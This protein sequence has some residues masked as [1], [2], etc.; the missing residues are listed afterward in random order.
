M[1]HDVFISHS[2]NDK[3][4]ADAM[5]HK[6]ESNGIRCWIAPR[7]ILPGVEWGDAIIQALNNGR[8]M[9]LV[10]S[11]KANDSQQIVKEVDRAA[12]KRVPIVAFRIE[13]VLPLGSLEYYLSNVHWLDAMTPPM[14]QHLNQLVESVKRLLQL[15]P[16][17]T[18]SVPQTTAA[19]PPETATAT[20][21]PATP[22]SKIDEI[23][24]TLET[25]VG[26]ELVYV[27]PGSFMMGSEY[28][29]LRE[30]FLGDTKPVH[31]VTIAEGFY[32][33]KYQVTQ[34]Q[35][36]A[37]R[38]NNPSHFKGENLP[39]EQVDSHHASLFVR[40]LNEKDDGYSYRLPSEAEWEYACRAG[41]TGEYSGDLDAM[42]WYGKNS[43]GKTHPVGSK[44]PNAFGLFDM[45][46]N[47][48]E[49]VQDWYHNTYQPNSGSA[50]TDGSAWLAWVGPDKPK[51]RVVRGGSWKDKA[52][53]CRSAYR[54][55]FDPD[56]RIFSYVGLR[57]V[58]VARS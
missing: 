29:G 4:I 32:M 21:P 33:G 16:R 38:G 9:I 7:D 19:S 22:I 50:P 34:A 26:I 6:L 42:A 15:P 11:S 41:T 36:Q 57:V 3:Q 55:R 31:R 58:A 2:S 8:V 12:S 53:F 17:Q 47:V 39:V 45:H 54:F 5:C 14:E 30:K 28:G 1:A 44:Q 18:T 13:D 24:R 10:F 51:V 48:W 35:W 52:Q 43:G 49:W 25:Q 27:P 56:W 23:P 40:N 37:L 20:P 46:G